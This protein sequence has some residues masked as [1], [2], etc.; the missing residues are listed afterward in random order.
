[1][2]GW[3]N[4]LFPLAAKKAN[5]D[6]KIRILGYSRG[7]ALALVVAKF[8]DL[9]GC[10][11]AAPG[12]NTSKG[13]GLG[14]LAYCKK[15]CA[16]DYSITIEFMALVDAVSSH[17]GGEINGVDEFMPS[18]VAPIVKKA[19]VYTATD[20]SKVNE[21]A[22]EH[23]PITLDAPRV[24][25]RKYKRDHTGDDGINGHNAKDVLKDITSDYQ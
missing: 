3:G 2:V 15:G 17:T 25:E 9:C 13:E 4:C 16:L 11:G 23:H 21:A 10:D 7:A 6:E 19:V 24:T 20:W 8:L 14:Y 18:Y 22:M 1:M 5:K 12:W